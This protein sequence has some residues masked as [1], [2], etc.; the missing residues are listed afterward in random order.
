MMHRAAALA[1]VL[2][3]TALPAAAQQTTPPPALPARPI[4]FPPF[5]E[6]TLPNGMRLLVV[7]NHS[8]PL[9]NLDLY[10][11]S[12]SGADPAQR[13]GTASIVAAM[14]DKGTATRSATQISEQV[15][16]VGGV[17]GAG[18]DQDNLT[19]SASMLSDQLQMAFE[20]LSDVALHPAFADQELQTVRAQQLAGLRAAQ[21]N[22]GYLASRTFEER[23]FG[24]EHPYGRRP[25]PASVAA[26]TREELAAW[27]RT[28]FV[29][30]NAM[31]VVSGDVTPAR[32]E[33]MARAAFGSWT[34]GAAPADNFPNPPAHERAEIL[35]VNRPGSV[36]SS[37]LVGNPGLAADSPDYYAAQV[38][39][40]ILGASGESRLERI[41]RGEHGWTYSSRSRYARLLGG[42]DYRANTEVRTAVTDSALSELVNQLR[43]IRDEAVPQAELDQAKSFLVS[44]FPNTLETPG[45]VAGRIAGARLLGLPASSV[46]E[47]PQRIAAV[48]AADVQR[49]ARRY[50]NP[51]RATIVVVGDASQILERV[52]AIAPVTVLDLEG[53]P[54]DPATI[55]PAA[56]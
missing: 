2:A 40:M 31:L 52:R 28:H 8:L 16:G 5:T 23:L 53:N 35:L 30:A 48:T 51:D 36:Q 50:L 41:L 43:R 10:I 11:R 21:G 55:R 42:G 17:L 37:I 18:A 46:T 54:V 4:Q 13:L 24:A 25:T 22:S 39:N 29:P 47:Y 32:A 3:G 15:E 7:E 1:I 19:V 34:G 44:S 6:R 27:H 9:V 14:L 38:L 49:V 12:G 56:N 33:Q 20:L 26:I 45:Q